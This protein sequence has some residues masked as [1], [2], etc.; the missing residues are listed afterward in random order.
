MLV[1]MID[2]KN[3]LHDVKNHL[4]D[5]KNGGKSVWAM[6]KTPEKVAVRCDAPDGGC[7][8][9]LFAYVA[10]IQRNTEF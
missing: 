10:D 3:H 9:P 8:P 4:D 1:D 6:S 7:V 5:V 2:A